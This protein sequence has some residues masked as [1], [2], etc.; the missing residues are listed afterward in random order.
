ML[1]ENVTTLE[2]SLD[3]QLNH[4]VY[5]SSGVVLAIVGITGSTLN[6][7]IITLILHDKK[8]RWTPFNV[9]L[10]NLSVGFKA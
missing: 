2:I 1:L 10:L 4:F 5:I 9:A 3:N 7:L 8:N 6:L